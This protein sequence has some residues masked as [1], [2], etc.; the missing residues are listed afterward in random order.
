MPENNST[1]TS[2]N[3]IATITERATTIFTATQSFIMEMNIG[4]RI[5]LKKMAAKIGPSI[6]MEPA[7]ILP[8]VADFARNNSLSYVSAGKYGGCVRGTRQLKVAKTSIIPSH[9]EEVPNEEISNNNEETN[10]D[11]S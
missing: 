8:Y 6:N 11:E 3:D 5:S 4:D 1:T 9:S 10:T 2:N 7:T